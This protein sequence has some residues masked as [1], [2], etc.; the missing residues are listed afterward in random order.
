MLFNYKRHLKI[1]TLER[2]GELILNFGTVAGDVMFQST[3]P[4]GNANYTLSYYFPYQNSLY[5]SIEVNVNGFVLLNG[6]A[7]I[8]AFGNLFYTSSS[9]G[10]AVYSRS[11]T[12]PSELSLLSSRIQSSFSNYSTFNA[13][14]AFVTTWYNVA[15]ASDQ[16]QLNTFQ[17]ILVT[18]HTN[19]FAVYYFVR[20]DS[21][22]Q[23]QC[24]FMGNS[25]NGSVVGFSMTA[26]CSMFGSFVQVINSGGL[27]NFISQNII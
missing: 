16:T 3:S 27:L 20:L 25:N 8:A 23:A 21:V 2:K 9:N 10:G 4:G 5:N 11:S 18:D 12:D 26:N 14:Q 24:V 13:T 7:F 19:S 6:T 17:L 1:K 15:L 22:S